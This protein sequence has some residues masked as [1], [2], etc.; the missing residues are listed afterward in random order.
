MATQTVQPGAAP[1]NTKRAAISNLAA[2]HDFRGL[3]PFANID[4]DDAVDRANSFISDASCILSFMSAAF[5]DAGALVG[6]GMHSEIDVRNNAIIGGALDGVATLVD[7]AGYL[8]D[9]GGE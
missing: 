5:S 8:L 1:A 9:A 3:A 2:H 6:K 4:S 7:M